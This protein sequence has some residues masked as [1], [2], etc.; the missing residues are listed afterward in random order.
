MQEE[1]NLIELAQNGDIGAF[2][3]LVERHQKQIYY[4]AFDLTGNKQDAEDLSQE[5]FIKMF[6]SL[7]KFRGDS[8]L[9]S[10]LYRVTVNSWVNE[11]RKGSGRLR[12]VQE[13]L[14][15]DLVQ[16]HVN[17]IGHQVAD[18]EK[19]AESA[20]LNKHLRKAF[21][22]LSP[23]ELSVFTLRHYHDLKMTE[24]GKILNLSVGTVKSLLFRALQKLRRELSSFRNGGWPEADHE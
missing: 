5:I 24:I 23:R 4:L 19:E 3:K 12:K 18:P 17:G 11:N 6:H 9:S 21:E 1:R 20:L 8:K 7:K 13:P 22:V 16:D 2:R 10:W 14:E 15:E